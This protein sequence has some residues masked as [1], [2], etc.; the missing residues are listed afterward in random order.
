MAL[1]CPWG[2]FST[3]RTQGPVLV[4]LLVVMVCGIFVNTPAF[5]ATTV[6]IIAFDNIAL[7]DQPV[8]LEASLRRSGL[9]GMLHPPIGGEVLLFYRKEANLLGEKL[10][11]VGGV[12]RIPYRTTKPGIYPFTVRL[13]ENPRYQAEP[14]EA[15]LFVRDPN[16]CL[17][18]VV[19]EETLGGMGSLEFLL[20]P[21]EKILPAPNSCDVLTRLSHHYD[22]VYLTALDRNS[23]G[24]MRKWLHTHKYP[25]APL[26]PV[27]SS[28]WNTA[29][30]D[31]EPLEGAILSL[32]ENHKH[33]AYVVVGTKALARAMSKKKLR[34]FLLNPQQDSTGGEQT[35]RQCNC[36]EFCQIHGWK[37]I[38]ACL[39]L[40]KSPLKTRREAK[41][42]DIESDC[43]R[44]RRLSICQER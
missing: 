15:S 7:P 1:S 40:G 28:L 12:A 36:N 35:K 4:L 19:A 38:E 34:V 43:V 3:R 18:F 33:P 25:K 10:T 31:A 8:S 42:E 9:L 41:Y 16:H 5:P 24:K 6:R 22:I 26:W 37:E 14:S 20:K 39:H 23:S 21:P 44:T 27:S 29:V 11:D 2:N 13:K 30:K 17:F 32:W